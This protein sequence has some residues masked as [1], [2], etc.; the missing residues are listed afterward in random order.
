MVLV[1][2]IFVG[3]GYAIAPRTTVADIAQQQD[4]A[5]MFA[6]HQFSDEFWAWELDKRLDLIDRLVGDADLSQARLDW[7]KRGLSRYE[8][9]GLA[10]AIR[11]HQIAAYQDAE[12]NPGLS[13]PYLGFAALWIPDA[14]GVYL[15]NRGTILINN[16]VEW[17]F[18]SFDDF[19]ATILHEVAHHIYAS[20]GYGVAH[21]SVLVSEAMTDDAVV[22]WLNTPKGGHVYFGEAYSLNPQERL[23]W[24]AQGMAEFIGLEHRAATSMTSLSER[25]RALEAL[26]SRWLQSL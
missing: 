7:G 8:M 20:F 13:V 3:V 17:E 19:A 6:H 23:A 26:K 11:D 12:I 21:D 22:L 2:C 14:R 18:L 5:A 24:D 25:F 9:L 16:S 1:F 10:R 15:Q 4:M